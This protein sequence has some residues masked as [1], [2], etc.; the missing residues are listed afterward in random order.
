MGFIADFL[1]KSKERKERINSMN[2]QDGAVSGLE[3]RKLS[4]NER[5]LNKILER[6]KQEAIREALHWEEQRR[7]AKERT[8]A[9]KM[10]MF[11]DNLFSDDNNL[12]KW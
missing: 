8:Q 4:H 11:D 10:M 6:D 3:T 2:E 9:R 5:E 12:L 1:R 7:K